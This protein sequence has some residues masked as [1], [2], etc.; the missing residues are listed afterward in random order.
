MV[1]SLDHYWHTKRNLHSQTMNMF[2]GELSFKIH[3][4]N[5]WSKLNGWMR[6]LLYIQVNEYKSKQLQQLSIKS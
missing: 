6:V 3:F 1:I 4:W 5:L 2:C